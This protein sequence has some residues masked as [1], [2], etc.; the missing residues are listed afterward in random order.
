[1]DDL[2]ARRLFLHAL[3]P[4]LREEGGG[5]VEVKLLPRTGP[6][7]S[8]SRSRS[9]SGRSGRSKSS[10]SP[11]VEVRLAPRQGRPATAQAAPAARLLRRELR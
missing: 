5:E 10:S 1:M 3:P 7:P 4:G 9:K 6:R 2:A 11:G 8:R